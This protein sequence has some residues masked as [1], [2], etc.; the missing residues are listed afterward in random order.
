MFRSMV[1]FS[2]SASLMVQLS[3]FKNSRWQ[4]TAILDIQKMAIISQPVCR[5][6]SCLV[7]EW[8][9]RLSLDFFARGLL[10]SYTHSCR[11]VT[12]TSA[13]LSCK[14]LFGV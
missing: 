13:R 1:G 7:L 2:G 14:T 12:F 9:F 11:A 8:G 10:P 5:T 6:T 3:I 4:L